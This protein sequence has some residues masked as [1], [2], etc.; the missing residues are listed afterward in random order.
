MS[1]FDKRWSDAPAWRERNDVA[2]GIVI[3][4]SVEEVIVEVM[5]SQEVFPVVTGDPKQPLAII[6]AQRAT[7]S[8]PGRIIFCATPAMRDRA[9]TELV[10][11]VGLGS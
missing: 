3:H 4:Q 5:S 1:D 9:L 8:S 2:P 11:Q 10:W 6:L 7:P